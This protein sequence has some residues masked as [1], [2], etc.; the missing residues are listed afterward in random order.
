MK[1]DESADLVM[2]RSKNPAKDFSSQDRF[3][4][5]NPAK[6]FCYGDR[7]VCLCSVKRLVGL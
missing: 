7:F 1:A 2:L 5:K 6:D 3:V 4:C